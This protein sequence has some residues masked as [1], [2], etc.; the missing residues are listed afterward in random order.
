[1]ENAK[2]CGNPAAAAV[3]PIGSWRKGCLL[4][5][6]SRV[7]RRKSSDI[8]FLFLVYCMESR[9]CIVLYNTPRKGQNKTRPSGSL[10]LTLWHEKIRIFTLHFEIP[11]FLYSGDV[12]ERRKVNFEMSIKEIE[13]EWKVFQIRWG[14]S[15]SLRLMLA[16]SLIFCR[17]QEFRY[18]V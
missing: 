3:W 9:Y 10:Y 1:M 13:K 17:L 5:Y 4:S 16:L 2:D 15:H 12:L 11:S 7:C 6:A 8:D 18:S 14:D